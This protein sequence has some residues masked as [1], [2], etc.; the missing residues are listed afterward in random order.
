[1][2]TVLDKILL[3]EKISQGN[4]SDVLSI[5]NE[6]NPINSSHENAIKNITARFN[7]V[8][9]DNR[10]GILTAPE[11]QTRWNKLNHD[12][13]NLID[14]ISVEEKKKSQNILYKV[15]TH[16]RLQYFKIII[17]SSILLLLLLPSNSFQAY[18]SLKVDKVSFVLRET[19]ELFHSQLL[20][21]VSFQNFTEVVI[22]TDGLNLVL[23]SVDTSINS[24]LDFLKLKPVE[25]N[26]NSSIDFLSPVNIEYLK[27]S[28]DAQI[29]LEVDNEQENRFSIIVVPT[30]EIETSLGL[31]S[32]TEFVSYMNS[33]INIPLKGYV[34]GSL[35][36][37]NPERIVV[38]GHSNATS[39]IF[40]KV[41]ADNAIEEDHLLVQNPVFLKRDD[42]RVKSSIVGNGIIK[43]SGEKIININEKEKLQLEHENSISLSFSVNSQHIDLIFQGKFKD[44]KLGGKSITYRPSRFIHLWYNQPYWLVIL[45]FFLVIILTGYVKRIKITLYP[46]PF[47]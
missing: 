24:N 26:Y 5:L 11:Y 19:N 45:L 6:Y 31:S 39:M 15:I 21:E 20:N 29:S 17:A 14:N 32:K 33:F 30:T 36:Y 35:S 37:T 27:G 44:I 42:N 9:I 2:K 28:K 3:K 16:R 22:P 7:K 10:R 41:T 43:I 1:M 18:I 46:P 38:K 47:L 12:L 13:L 4:T 40:S 8:E 34:D 25:Q 23:D